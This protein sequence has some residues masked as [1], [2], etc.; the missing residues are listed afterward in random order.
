MSQ[1]SIK[2]QFKNFQFSYPEITNPFD[3]KYRG[4]RATLTISYYLDS[5]NTIFFT[6][7]SDDYSLKNLIE[8]VSD[9]W[10]LIDPR[11][12]RSK[13]YSKLEGPGFIYIAKLNGDYEAKLY[14][15]FKSKNPKKLISKDIVIDCFYCQLTSKFFNEILV[16]EFNE[17]QEFQKLRIL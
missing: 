2:P 11:F 6:L 13:H 5:D 1:I 8:K 3:K 14:Y 12:G 16:K 15:P 9:D 17:F 4:F 10:A 7:Y